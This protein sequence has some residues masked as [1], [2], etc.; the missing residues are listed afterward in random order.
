MSKRLEKGARKKRSSEDPHQPVRRQP[1]RFTASLRKALPTMQNVPSK[2]SIKT[3]Q[4][5]GSEEVVSPTPNGNIIVAA[6]DFGTTYSGYAFSFKHE[7]NINPLKIHGNEWRNVTQGQM[8]AKQ[9]T[10]LLLT[11]ERKLHSFGNEAKAKYLSLSVE[12]KHEDWYFFWEFKMSLHQVKEIQGN[13]QLTAENGKK[14]DALTVFGLSI[15]YLKEHLLEVLHRSFSGVKDR[16]ITWVITV[17]AIWNDSA[18]K[19]M[20]KA[21]EMAGITKSCI[22]IALEPEAASIYCRQLPITRDPQTETGMTKFPSGTR[23]LILDCGGGTVDVTVHEVLEDNNLKE[24][25]KATGGRWG[26]TVVNKAFLNFISKLVGTEVFQ[27]FSTKHKSDY[28]EMLDEFEN[29]KRMARPD[30]MEIVTIRIPIM[31][32]DMFR[33]ASNI[34]LN[35]QVV[36]SKYKDKVHIV[37]DKLRIDA[38][39]FKSFFDDSVRDI[40]AHVRDLMDSFPRPVKAILMVGGFSESPVLQ[41]A[42]KDGFQKEVEVIIPLDASLCIMKGAVLFGHQPSK[43]TERRCR[44]TYGVATVVSFDKE[45]H[46]EAKKIEID[47]EE[48]CNDIFD[49]HVEVGQTVVTGE[50]QSTSTYYPMSATDTVF[51][52]VLFRSTNPDPK[53]VDDRGCECVGYYL[54]ERTP[55]TRLDSIEVRLIFGGSDIVVESVK[56][57][58]SVHRADFKMD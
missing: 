13:Y 30:S 31:L 24:L 6:I 58:G 26:G 27:D 32:Q 44:F 46:P 8:N 29:K 41:K 15:R 54:L 17:P 12:N 35:D 9:Q 47:G 33:G 50:A 23:Y 45:Q 22:E 19:F 20:R 10:C 3:R 56:A 11:S 7:F 25:H 28:L 36:K 38:D 1:D 57:D 42:V 14:L 43:I 48:L 21:A 53:F 55:G 51:P 18:K 40:I 5:L 52:V 34:P 16:D 49:K 37:G 4:S 39:L 2:T